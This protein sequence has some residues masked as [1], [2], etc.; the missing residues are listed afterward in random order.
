MTRYPAIKNSNLGSRG[1]RPLQEPVRVN[2][3]NL[4]LSIGPEAAIVP[5]DGLP[6]FLS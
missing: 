3:F 1:I 6:L 4:T 5:G 2:F